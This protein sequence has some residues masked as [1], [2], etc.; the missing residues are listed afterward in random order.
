MNSTEFLTN[1][2]LASKV[3]LG[4]LV[5]N[6]AVNLPFLGNWWMTPPQLIWA[7]M[8]GMWLGLGKS[9]MGSKDTYQ[10]SVYLKHRKYHTAS[11]FFY[12]VS[13]FIYFARAITAV[14]D[15]HVHGISPYD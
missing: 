6:V 14:M 4:F 5:F 7:L 10:K 13:W 15:I 1:M 3:E 9:K 12:L 8:K 2:S 11:L